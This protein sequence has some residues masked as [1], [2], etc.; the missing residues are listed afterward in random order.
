MILI[1]LCMKYS[2]CI[3]DW[4]RYNRFFPSL[5]LGT[6]PSHPNVK[7]QVHKWKNGIRSNNRF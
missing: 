6:V 2:P 5:K 3:N 4:F 7:N 1:Y